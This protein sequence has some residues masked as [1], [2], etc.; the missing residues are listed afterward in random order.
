MNEVGSDFI[1]YRSLARQTNEYGRVQANLLSA[2]MGVKDFI[3]KGTDQSV[4]TVLE[5]TKTTAEVTD[6]IRNL[7]DDEKEIADI[8]KILSRVAQYQG[9]FDKAVQ[10]QGVREKLVASLDSLGPSMERKLTEIMTTAYDDGD[11][12]SAMQTAHVLRDF[13]LVR[14]YVQ[15]FLLNNDQASFDRARAE[16]AAFTETTGQM[17]AGLQNPQRK[18][19]ATEVSEMSSAY[20]GDLEKTQAAISKRNDVITGTLDT[21]GPMIAEEIE[22]KKLEIKGTQDELGPRVQAAVAQ[23]ETVIA[24]VGI[25]ALIIG[26]AAAYLIGTG[27]TKP[28]SAM[29][30]AMG[31]LAKKDMS[32][33]IP[34][35]ENKDE[36]G[37]MARAVEVFKENMIKADQLAEQQRIEDEKRAQRAKTIETLCTEFDATSTEA[38]KSVASAAT[39]LQGAS[40]SMSATAEETTRQSAAGRRPLPNRPRP[41]CKPW[42]RRPRNCR[43]PSARSVGRL[44]RPLRSPRRPCAR[45]EQTNVKVQGLAE[46]ANKIGEVVELIT[47][48]ADQTNLLAL[49]ATIEAARAGDA[50]KGFAVVASEVKNLANQTAKATEEIGTQIAGIQSS[51]QEAVTAIETIVKTIVEINEISSAIASAVEEQSAATQE[52]ARNVEQA[53]T[54]TQEVS[55]NIS[56]VN[57]AAN[58]T[59]AAATQIQNAS[60]DLSR[61]S[62]V[63]RTEVE[64]FLAN[65]RAA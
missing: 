55:S 64:K 3:I 10:F 40:E 48:I 28:I 39:E 12:E 51:T 36:I 8:D 1:D 14:L 44:A 61:Q 5:R 18:G 56:G 35:T 30:A 47:D 21:I 33:E 46:A 52:I 29:T 23:S 34:A 42:P 58:D 57:Q 50:G 4:A 37:E 22:N 17:T 27:I 25:L 38:V 63:L 6:A 2:R 11:A 41:M 54:G 13:L 49:N 45:P 9:A 59:G 65:V 7:T 20:I 62:E 24:V 19:L 26:I 32:T 16:A 53:A 15:K 43:V 31:R 60:G